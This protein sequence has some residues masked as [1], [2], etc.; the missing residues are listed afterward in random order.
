LAINGGL[1]GGSGTITGD[2]S[3][4]A[5]TLAAGFSP[6]TLNIQGNL[7]LAPTSTVNVDLWGANAGQYDVI[8]VSGT[9]T[10]DGTL[11]ASI[12]NGYV[13][14]GENFNVL[15]FGARSGAFATHNLPSDFQHTYTASALN[16]SHA[17][18]SG[19]FWDND[20]G[21]FQWTNPLNW[22][23]N[24]RLPGAT[25]A[26]TINAGTYAQLASGNQSIGSLNIGNGKYLWLTGGSLTVNGT[27]I[28]AGDIRLD[29]GALILVGGATLGGA[30]RQQGGTLT[31]GTVAFNGPVDWSGG[32]W[33]GGQMTTNSTLSI[34]GAGS[35]TLSGAR[36]VEVGAVTQSADVLMNGSFVDIHSTY[37]L[38][39]GGLTGGTINLLVPL[40]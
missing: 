40:P 6:G 31:G 17:V 38:Q 18:V 14:N 3:L 29:G 39:S 12:G 9:A 35:R 1:L 8:N 15:T 7:T 34:S 26:V 20:S 16:L 33:L 4:G 28:T 22:N 21:D 5:A 2:V 10:L 37:D 25:D 11:N 13:P 30:Y 23:F 32:D 24:T 36:L 19:F 27:T